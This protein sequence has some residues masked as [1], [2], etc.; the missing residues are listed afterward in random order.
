MKTIFH[1][2]VAIAV[3]FAAVI[4]YAHLR[5][6]WDEE[7]RIARI[8]RVIEAR[9]TLLESEIAYRAQFAEKSLQQAIQSERES[10]TRWDA[11][12]DR[13]KLPGDN[14]VPGFSSANANRNVGL[15]RLNPNQ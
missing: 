6:R 8:D 10:Q 11:A 2:L 9:R 15:P 1:I 5:V 12:K 7:A 13:G 14:T 4:G 3:L